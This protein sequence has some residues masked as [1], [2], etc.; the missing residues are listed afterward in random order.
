M[1]KLFDDI[2]N[3]KVSEA[4]VLTNTRYTSEGWF[5]NF[6]D[7]IICFTDHHIQFNSKG[8][9]SDGSCFVYFGKNEKN[10]IKVFAKYGTI[11]KKIK[12]PNNIKIEKYDEGLDHVE[13]ELLRE[14]EDR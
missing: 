7:G 9:N 8:N 4:L 6:F 13:R 12:I 2:K 1:E 11:V 3:K 10:F 14:L 5:K